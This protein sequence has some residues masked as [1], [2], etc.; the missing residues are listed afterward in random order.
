MK[1]VY[2]F[3][4]FGMIMV[5]VSGCSSSQKASSDDMYYSSPGNGNVKGGSS[6][7]QVDYYSTAP[8]DQYVRMRVQDPDRW[9]YFDDYNGYDSYYAPASVGFGAS[10]GYGYPSY[11]FGYGLGFGSSFG[12]GF[13]DPYMCWNS[14][15]LWN[16]WYNPYFYNPYYG[17][18]YLVASSKIPATAVYAHLRSFNTTGYRNGLSNLNTNSSIRHNNPRLTSYSPGTRSAD[19]SIYRPGGYNGNNSGFGRASSI[20]NSG[21][22]RSFSSPSSFGGGSGMR[23]GG[24]VGR[25]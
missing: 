17:G 22:S 1:H 19:G 16:S 2:P 14:Y 4:A 15:F 3:L 7:N 5:F 8:S 6:A 9:S 12:F 18:G 20:S 25:H 13:W 11:G 23:G 10:Y 24:G 21:S